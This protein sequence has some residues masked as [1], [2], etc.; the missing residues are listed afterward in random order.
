LIHIFSEIN[1]ILKILIILQKKEQQWLKWLN[2]KIVDAK[3]DI[4][5]LLD[6]QN[7]YESIST[8]HQVTLMS[9]EALQNEDYTKFSS[10]EHDK[11]P[12]DILYSSNVIN[13][14]LNTRISSIQ[15]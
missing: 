14:T 15:N 12:P 8:I 9:K 10:L 5:K 7:K 3:E 6:Y 13:K 11:I 1:R 4:T 2:K